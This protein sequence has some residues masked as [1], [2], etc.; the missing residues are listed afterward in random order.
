[1][2]KPTKTQALLAASFALA[3]ALTMEVGHVLTAKADT[4]T[5]VAGWE[6]IAT[7]PGTQCP[8][9]VQGHV[10]TLITTEDGQQTRSGERF[11]FTPPA[12][13]L[14]DSFVSQ[15]DA[16]QEWYEGW[17]VEREEEKAARAGDP[18]QAKP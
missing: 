5:R 18:K 4:T 9:R 8:F 7:E 12:G 11:E 17:V 2:P 1:M 10:V 16:L 14:C 13:P 6:V 15:R 3:G